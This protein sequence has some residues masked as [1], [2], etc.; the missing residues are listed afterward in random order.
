[1]GLFQKIQK[2]L[3]QIPIISSGTNLI[4]GRRKYKHYIFWY[5]DNTTISVV[6]SYKFLSKQFKA[7]N[8]KVKSKCDHLFG[9]VCSQ[10]QIINSIDFPFFRADQFFLFSNTIVSPQHVPQRTLYKLRDLDRCYQWTRSLY[11][12]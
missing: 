8:W 9:E 7:N 3:F 4:R 12:R 6:I 1:M 5:N 2:L 11:L 10:C